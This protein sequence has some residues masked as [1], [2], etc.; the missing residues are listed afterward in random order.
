[1]DAYLLGTGT[2]HGMPAPMCPCQ[3]CEKIERKRPSLFVEC[4]ERTILFD[5]SPDFPMQTQDFGIYN[6]EDVF[7][8]HHHHDHS[9]GLKDLYH[10]TRD[11]KVSDIREGKKEFA[12]SYFGNTYQLY[13]SPYTIEVFEKEIP[14]IMESER[15]VNNRMED[16]STVC[17]GETKVTSFVAEHTRG[18]IGF[19]I[20]RK[21]E[22]IV[23]LPDHGELRTDATFDNID[24]LIGDGGPILGYKAHGSKSDM[25]SVMSEINADKTYLV[26]VSEHIS[27]RPTKFLEERAAE[28]NARV[29]DDGY[30]VL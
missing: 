29:V 26:N 25:K 3:Y 4:E 21:D 14:Y 7:V 9:S 8:T 11:T 10:T 15:L 5:V 20:E 12:D 18:Y 28:Y 22:K 24:I 17:I 16:N 23:Y 30:K 19:I 2:S 6:A 27:Q 1:M 13:L